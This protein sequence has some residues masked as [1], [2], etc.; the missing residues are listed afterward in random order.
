MTH[1][2]H[3]HT[4]R[5]F[6]TQTAGAAVGMLGIATTVQPATSASPRIGVGGVPASVDKLTVAVD[7]WGW[8]TLNTLGGAGPNFLQD[9][10]NL[11]L[12]FRDENHNIVSGLLTEWSLTEQGVKGTIHPKAKWQDGTP[13]TAE[14]LKWN[15]E[16]MRGDYAP[17]FKPHRLAARLRAQI[18]EVQVIDA[19]RFFVKTKYPVPEFLAFYAGVGYHLILFGPGHYYEKVGLEAAERNPLGG[20]PYLLKEF[21]AGER[22][23]FERWEDFWGDTAWYH[24]PQH[25]TLEILLA[26]DAAARFALLMSR[27]ADVAVNIPYALAKDLP[28]SESFGQRGVNP[29]K[30]GVW[31]QTITATGN[32]NLVFVNLQAMKDSPDKP[33]PE[34]LKP[35]DD[36]RVREAMELAVDK[37]AISKRAHFGFTKAMTSFWFTGS[38]G[39][40]REPSVSPYDPA[41]AKQLLREAGYPNGFSTTI[42]WGNFVN[43]PGIREWLEAAASFWKE[44]GIEVKLIEHEPTEFIAKC[45]RPTA[46]S[47]GGV[48]DRKLRPL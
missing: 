27:Q 22:V 3:G 12:L 21:K 42:H 34:E 13:I 11:L 39:H 36:I 25:K 19:K 46:G 16:A 43:S 40:Q 44:A 7:S 5:Q 4:R 26:P 20:G 18:D 23:V 48:F 37:A 9:Y 24:K 32:Y 8:D 47:T 10:I 29:N 17:K 30:G 38:V 45:C 6:L 35:F 28:R 41:R 14:D 2:R 31:T 1:D 15:F 33:T